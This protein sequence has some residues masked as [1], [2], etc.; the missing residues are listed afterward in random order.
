MLEFLSAFSVRLIVGVLFLVAGIISYHMLG[1][2]GLPILVSI[3]PIIY[4]L[5]TLTSA[6]INV[7]ILYQVIHNDHQRLVHLAFYNSILSFISIGVLVVFVVLFIVGINS[8][9]EKCRKV[10]EEG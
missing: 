10:Q 2:K 3:G 1:S 8:L 7:F 4:G 9:A 5:W 6:V